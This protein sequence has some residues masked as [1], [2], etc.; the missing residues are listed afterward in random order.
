MRQRAFHHE[1]L[2]YDGNDEF[3][4]GTVPYLRDAIE[5]GEAALV[6]VGAKRTRALRSELGSD[7]GEVRF[8]EMEE[9][10]RN[11]ARII[12]FWNEFLSEH[13]GP[14]RPARGIGEPVWQGRSAHELDEC[15]RHE[16]L[17]N[18]AFD[19]ELS[20]SLL[21][22]YDSRRLPDDALEAV[23]HCHP[24]VSGNR[25]PEP[26]AAAHPRDAGVFAGA[27]PVRPADAAMLSF[28][29]H[30]LG[31]ARSLVGHEADLAG[32]GPERASDLITAASE[33]AA[34]SVAHGGG[35]GTIWAWR[36]AADLVVEVRDA[37]LI[38]EPLV[39][40]RRP[41]AAQQGGRGLWIVNLLCDLVQI[42][43]GEDGTAI[44]L[45]MRLDG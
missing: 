44:R 3:L 18:L 17:L 20:W 9:V 5:A 45:R 6:A 42:R 23:A 29:L 4:A 33:L 41:Q 39:G 35:R 26:V 11:P 19:G 43:S 13:A 2:F 34:N 15:R 40:R 24:Y 27:L 12:P 32:L 28:D 38:E 31:E 36:D 21:C 30:A 1:V 37:G 14:G 16:R 8:A 25:T 7:A 10:G 22:P